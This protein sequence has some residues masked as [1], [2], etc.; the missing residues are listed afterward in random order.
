MKLFTLCVLWSAYC[1]FAQPVHLS[2]SDTLKK[3]ITLQATYLA[4]EELI[5]EVNRQTGATLSVDRA[6]ADEKAHCFVKYRPAHEVLTKLASLLFLEWRRQPDDSFRLGR[7]TQ[8]RDYELRLAEE[9][10]KAF[11]RELESLMARWSRASER[12]YALLTEEKARIE[13]EMEQLASQ[14][15][16]GWEQKRSDLGKR[17]SALG[18]EGLLG[19]LGGFVFRQL[20]TDQRRRFMAG[21][22]LVASTESDSSL[23]LPER[24][25]EWLRGDSEEPPATACFYQMRLET[26]QF[27]LRCQLFKRSEQNLT[28]LHASSI[29][30][31]NPVVSHLAS[32]PVQK[33]MET[34]RSLSGARSSELKTPLKRIPASQEARPRFLGDWLAFLSER[35]DMNILAPAFRQ[36]FPK[37]PLELP[38]QARTLEEALA[39]LPLSEISH[40]LSGSYLCL[41]YNNYWELR[42]REIPERLIKP[43]EQKYAREG[44]MLDDYAQLIFELTPLQQ[45]SLRGGSVKAIAFPCDYLPIDALLFWA[46]LFPPQKIQVLNRNPIPYTSLDADQRRAF[47]RALQA[48]S[49]QLFWID[50]SS[51]PD[52][53]AFFAQQDHALITRHV[54]DNLFI[55]RTPGVMP[56]DESQTSL[57]TQ[58]SARRLSLTFHF[59]LSVTE[60]VA[61]SW[62]WINPAPEESKDDKE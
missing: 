1:A 13:Q 23:R 26:Q 40:R 48:H 16:P 28:T 55:D 52:Q 34:W 21:E 38:N 54:Q 60:S 2:E 35:C 11:Y 46:T 3:P 56:P 7:S 50:F 31:L 39:M 42:W 29:Y 32:H 9:N 44:L 33:Q 58:G 51:P 15:P 57:K 43:L 20:P 12:D 22:T 4:L 53:L 10:Q 49:E 59:G 18:A 24:L 36:A 30:S 62:Q 25:F 61:F 37:E 14:Q 5:R 41:Q 6:I 17:L 27:Q 8:A 19:W 47:Q 45:S